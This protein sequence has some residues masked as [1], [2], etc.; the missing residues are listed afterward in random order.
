MYFS[1]PNQPIEWETD[2]PW[3]G[4]FINISEELISNNQHLDYSFL[5]Y[6]LHEPLL[7]DEQEATIITQNFKLAMYEYKKDDY[8]LD[9]ILAHC[10]II[11]AH[12][13]QF[14]KRQF[15][16][17]KEQ[18]NHL[19]VQ[20]FSLLKNYYA[21][22]PKTSVELPSVNYFAKQANITPNYLSDL[23]KYYTGQS[24]LEHIHQLIINEAKNL[25][26][27]KRLS[28]S[29][30]AYKLGFEYPSYFTRLFKKHIGV[31]PSKFR[32]K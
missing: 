24:T 10:N 18:Y 13:A 17:R 32:N 19:V 15:G 23:I 1:S 27:K 12:I 5:N 28:I 2:E 25:L 11:F 16:D 31:S 26:D 20:F 21:N 6:G 14:Y 29:E 4:F 7:L 22:P 8:S 9:I 3:I 30:V